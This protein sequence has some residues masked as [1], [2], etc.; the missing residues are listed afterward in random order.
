MTEAELESVALGL[1]PKDRARLAE[2]LLA[3]LEDLSAAERED[4]WVEEALHRD[5]EVEANPS[6]ARSSSDVFAAARDRIAR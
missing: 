4:L 3:S 5:G 6:L 2:R 1:P